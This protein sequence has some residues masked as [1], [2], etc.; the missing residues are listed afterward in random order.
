MF[1]NKKMILIDTSVL[2]DYLK[3]LN[4]KGTQSLDYIIDT[5]I[6]ITADLNSSIAQNILNTSIDSFNIA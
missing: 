3:G 1:P 5:G 6:P 4:N 2:V